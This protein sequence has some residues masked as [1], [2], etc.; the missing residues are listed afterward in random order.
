MQP[1]RR[2]L[3]FLFLALNAVANGQQKSEADLIAQV[4]SSLQHEDREK[5]IKLFPGIDSLS[6]WVLQYAD[7]NSESY[8]KMLAVQHSPFLMLEYDS[9]IRSEAKKNFAAFYKKSKK[10]NVHWGETVFQRFELEKIRRGSGL[11]TER[12]APLSFMGYVFFKDMLTQKTYGFT[13]FDLMQVN[14]LWYGG[15]LVNIFQV[16]TK[17]KFKAALAEEKRLMRLGLLEDENNPAEHVTTDDEE[18]RDKPSRMKEV[19]ERKFYRGAF[20]GEIKVQ[21][22]VRHI[23]GGCPEGV[24]SWEALFKFGD[25]DEYVKMKVSRTEEGHWVFQEA[26]GSMELELDGEVYTGTYTMSDDKT[27][28]TVELNETPLLPKKLKVLDEILEFETQ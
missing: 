12:I 10:L 21:L 3:L 1:L 19:A 20:D 15:E 26:L 16:D 25:E 17:D 11:I 23:K 9:I 22:Y 27:E 6:A 4:F 8:Q 14:G 2:Y 18:D 28:Y 7:K 5:Y 24:C 13:V